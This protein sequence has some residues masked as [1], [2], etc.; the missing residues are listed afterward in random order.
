MDKSDRS[1]LGAA[2]STLG[3]DCIVGAAV[4]SVSDKFRIR[5]FVKT[6]A[7]YTAFLPGGELSRQIAD[8]VFLQLGDEFDWD[9][10]LA[11]PA[12]EVTPVRLGA[13]AMLGWTSWMS[14]NWSQTDRTIRTDARF[15]VVSR[16][17]QQ[18]SKAGGEGD[19]RRH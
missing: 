6:F 5:I 1:R 4:F 19:E 15:H 12:G 8:A 13:G 18:R 3:R 14:P 11:I 17:A 10:E 2:S 7:Q 9:V 16:L